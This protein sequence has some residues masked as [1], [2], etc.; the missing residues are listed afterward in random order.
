MVL[1]IDCVQHLVK[2]LTDNTSLKKKE[3]YFMS[4]SCMIFS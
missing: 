2:Q 4:K 3:K 1:N